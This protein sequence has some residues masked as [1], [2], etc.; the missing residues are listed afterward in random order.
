MII[1]KNRS[2]YAHFL[3]SCKILEDYVTYGASSRKIKQH[4]HS[5]STRVKKEVRTTISDL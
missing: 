3:I 1:L 4:E 2:N 5:K